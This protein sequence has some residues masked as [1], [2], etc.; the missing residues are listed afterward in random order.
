MSVRN[1]YIENDRSNYVNGS[2]LQI[3]TMAF[4]SICLSLLVFSTIPST[5]AQKGKTI[6]LL[7]TENP[8]DITCGSMFRSSLS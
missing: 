5:S 4:L 2:F 8:S 7:I 6:I 3:P 1:K